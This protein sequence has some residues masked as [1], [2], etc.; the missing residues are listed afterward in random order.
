[1]S[2]FLLLAE[3]NAASVEAGGSEMKAPGGPGGQGG[4]AA[5]WE[6]S[7]AGLPGQEDGLL[8]APLQDPLL[9]PGTARALPG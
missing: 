5:R 4:G 2:S 1:M 3:A 6:A 8:P 9:Q 7:G